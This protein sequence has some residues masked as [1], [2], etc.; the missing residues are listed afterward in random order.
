MVQGGC[1]FRIPPILSS[2]MDPTTNLFHLQDV[3]SS[4]HYVYVVDGKA[5][6]RILDISD[7]VNPTEADSFGAPGLALDVAVLD[8][9]I[10]LAN[11][12]GGLYILRYN[13]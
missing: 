8:G 7:P 10:Y 3:A 13:R 6:L 9:Y 12:S 4:G 2:Q 5:G 1:I 11:G